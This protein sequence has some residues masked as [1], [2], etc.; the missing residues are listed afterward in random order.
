[1]R[2]PAFSVTMKDV[3]VASGSSAYLHKGGFTC[4]VYRS[5]SVDGGE[6]LKKKKRAV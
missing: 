2:H 3:N 5:A 6:V 4:T 1:V